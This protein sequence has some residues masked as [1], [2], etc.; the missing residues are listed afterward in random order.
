[1]R[2]CKFF[3]TLESA[4]ISMKKLLIASLL[5]APVFLFAQQ[6]PKNLTASNGTFIGFYEYKPTDYNAN[7]TTKYPLIIFLH[8]IGERGDGVTNLPLVLYNGIPKNIA[9]GHNMRFTWNGKT[10]TFLV[11]SPQ[12][13]TIYG[14]WQNFYVDEMIKYAKQN[15]RV[16]TDR[17]FL[18]G[19]SLGGGGVWRF[20]SSSAA[21]ASQLAGIAP[22]CGTCNLVN[23]CNIASAN[24]PVW[25]FH[26]Q[27]D[28]TVGVGCTTGN[29]Q[30]VLN[31]SP[32][33]KPLMS[34]YPSG[35]HGIWNRSY[36]TEYNYHEP[37]MYEWFLG[38]NKSLPV[39]SLPKANAGADVS[40]S[41]L[42]GSVNLNGSG[43][44]DPDGNLVR[45]SWR[46]ISG[47][48]LGNIVS[49]ISSNGITNV[50]GLLLGT[51][52]Y[53]LK[54]VDNRAGISL[55]TVVVNV[56]SNLGGGTSNKPPV[57]NAGPDFT[58]TLPTSSVSVN[59]S[60]S[61][62]EDGSIASFSWTKVSGPS[63]F[64]IANPAAANTGISN[65]AQGTYTFR[66]TVTDNGGFTNSDDVI[67]NVNAATSLPNQNPVA[68]AGTN[69]SINLPTNS[70]TLDGSGSYDPDGAISSYTWSKVNG[71]ATVTTGNLNSAQLSL[72][73]LGPGTYGF[74]LMVTDNKGAT[75]F[76][77]IS[78]TV[79]GA[80]SNQAPTARA[81]ADVSVTLPINNTT[82]NGSSSSDAD[83]TIT[84]YSWTKISGPAQFIIASPSS[85]STAITNLAQGSYTFRL[86][87]TDNGGATH[88]DDVIVL[89]NA[90]AASLPPNQGPVANAG[91]DIM[92]SLPANT[93]TLNAGGSYDPDGSIATYVWN[94][95]SGPDV[96]T[97]SSL[98]SSTV[99][100]T[101]L[102][103][104]T[105]GFQLTVTDN[106]GA[107]AFDYI[108]VTVATGTPN[109]TPVANAGTDIVMALPNNSATLNG[110]TSRDPDGTITSYSWTK[111]SGPASFNLTNAT[112]ANASVSGLAQGVYTFRLT[113]T[114][115]KE[116]SAYDDVLVTVNA[117]TG[118]NLF[119]NANAGP[120]INI[121]LPANSATL[122]ASG[123]SDPDGSIVSYTWRK[124][125][126]PDVYNAGN[127]NS[128]SVSLTNL[129]QGTYGFELKVTDNGG[130]IGFD[131]ILVTVNAGSGGAP[132][133][134][135]VANAGVNFAIT[136]PNNSA[137]LNGSASSDPDGSIVTYNWSKLSGP[138]QGSVSNPN[139]ATTTA[140]GLVQGTYF[141]R[142]IVT[143]N[144]GASHDDTVRIVVNP[145]VVLVP[146]NLAPIAKAGP[147]L[148]ITL[149]TSS[150]YLNGYDSY[151]PEGN[152]VS[153]GWSQISGPANS[154]ITNTTA[155]ATTVTSLVQGTYYFRFA[156]TDNVGQT[157]AD[158]MKLTVNGTAAGATKPLAAAEELTVAEEKL[159]VYPNPAS[160][161]V[162]F[163]V[164]S[165]VN[166]NAILRLYD[167]TG[168]TVYTY[169]FAKTAAV[170]E[171][172]V[173]ISQLNH[174][175]YYVEI[176]I[177][178]RKKVT[179]K[180]VK[181]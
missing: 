18:T 87:V 77:W 17:I 173:A 36:D 27:D 68:K 12:L 125:S 74:Q 127:M 172:P 176:I 181:Q 157:T 101:N 51:Y 99:S 62:D 69:F 60:S 34:I 124:I 5:L 97:A 167:G 92:V 121:S 130:A 136:L 96:Y 63:Q 128:S 82:L 149:P 28:G 54:V 24:L 178:A 14:D 163:R 42:L 16:D 158:T 43:S 118:Y 94:K 168:K 171:I 170:H 143:D 105:Y 88:S 58:I 45:F 72:S 135:P 162:K 112:A 79:N 81:G 152:I 174:G 115:N 52:K 165:A 59:G 84:G 55:D 47:P 56:L 53:E 90:A 86:T 95:I 132:N 83:G 156:L 25:A 150:A 75:A 91:P 110:T 2:L 161:T 177:D 89:V 119:P 41:S 106:R 164:S 159:T 85:A 78:V 134:A 100:L 141:F 13:S 93:A 122:N 114:D 67:I 98:N 22:V 30:G 148:T 21:N 166:G 71:P 155:G 107:M 65:L 32:A 160:T 61:Y 76:D 104:G 103:Q 8:G 31:C 70:T 1:M 7:P 144:G 39:N 111:I 26:A 15:L 29:I 116:A 108:L 117:S 64:T 40:I 73:N 142:L 113:V 131:Y 3:L 140:T 80:V 169:Q 9:N 146:G 10:E 37:N 145:G 120:D 139:I 129:T 175:I 49:A 38:Q 33:V 23:A 109:Q 50:T 153:W 154:K 6:V 48:T 102:V 151:D 126:G 11:L 4:L 123:S 35:G 66:L 179:A 147:D 138:T 46:Q 20:A 133:K 44:F 57:A 19:L 137:T 180:F